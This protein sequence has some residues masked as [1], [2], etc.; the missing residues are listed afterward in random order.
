MAF[1]L[2]LD[3]ETAWAAGTHEY[4]PMGV[5]VVAATDVFRSRDF[6]A[7]RRAP[8]GGAACFHGLFPSLAEVN[9]YLEG[10][11]SQGKQKNPK[12]LF[13]SWLP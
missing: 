9:A 4:R 13:P 1:A 11:R 12:I 3:G 5:A 2:W 6:A 7:G 8:V 10:R